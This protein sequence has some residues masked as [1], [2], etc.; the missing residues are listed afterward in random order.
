M[1]TLITTSPKSKLLCDQDEEGSDSYFSPNK[2]SYYKR[3][4]LLNHTQSTSSFRQ[5]YKGFRTRSSSYAS[6]DNEKKAIK[7][8]NLITSSTTAAGPSVSSTAIFSSKSLG[9]TTAEKRSNTVPSSYFS[10]N[11]YGFYETEENYHDQD[12]VV[13]DEV[14]EETENTFF[15]K[16]TKY[17]RKNLSRSTSWKSCVLR[18]VG[19]KSR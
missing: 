2:P 15:A 11:K 10:V 7:D 4:N 18:A 19:V 9:M 8:D 13:E 6:L 16:E 1:T 3:S 12:E 5:K 14:E 17:S